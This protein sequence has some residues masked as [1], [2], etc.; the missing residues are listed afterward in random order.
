MSNLK[1]NQEGSRKKKFKVNFFDRGTVRR[2]SSEVSHER[3][4]FFFKKKQHQRIFAIELITVELI[5]GGCNLLQALLRIS[6]EGIPL[7]A[8][9][10]GVSE[11]IACERVESETLSIFIYGKL[12]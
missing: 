1:K 7:G 3:F 4:R 5:F 11:N 2:Y 6:L 9:V 8:I 12:V 10:H